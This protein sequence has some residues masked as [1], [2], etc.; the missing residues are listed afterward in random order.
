MGTRCALQLYAETDAAAGIVAALALDEVDRIEKKYSRYNPNSTIS[1]INLAAASGET[2]LLDDETAAL[3]DYAQACFQKSEGLFDI[4]AGVLRRA[5]DFESERMPDPSEIDKL[6]PMIGMDKLVW[7]APSL[8]FK[9]KGMEIDFGGIGKE[10]AVDRV[11][12]LLMEHGITHGLIDLGGD[13]FV[14]GPHPDGQPWQISLRDPL[15]P[16]ALIG[17]V[18]IHQGALATSGDYERC[19]DFNGRRCCHIL[20][21]RTGWPVQGL[22]SVTALASHCMVAGSMTTIAMLKG[23]SGIQWLERLGVPHQWATNE[24]RQGGTLC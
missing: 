20:N 3:L 7:H 22:S 8:S 24:G 13:L 23:Q 14:L 17:T 15:K 6:L 4:T 5:W 21:P 2:V 11:A 1:A 18:E 10:Y 12:S 9:N 19:I 16:D